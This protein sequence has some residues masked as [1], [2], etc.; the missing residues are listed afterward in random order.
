[1]TIGLSLGVEAMVGRFAQHCGE[2]LF[3]RMAFR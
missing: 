2:W 3:V 1:M